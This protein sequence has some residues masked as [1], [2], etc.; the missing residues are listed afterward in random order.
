VSLA[1]GTVRQ[2]H[3]TLAETTLGSYGKSA[4]GAWTLLSLLLLL[5]AYYATKLCKEKNK[6]YRFKDTVD[7]KIYITNL[8]CF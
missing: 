7:K 1:L 5:L 4:V 8:T 2:C 6:S 3:A